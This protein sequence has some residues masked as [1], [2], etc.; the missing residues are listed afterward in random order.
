MEIGGLLVIGTERHESRRID[1]Q[2]RGRSGRQGE[3]GESQFFVSFEDEIVRLYST[4]KGEKFIDKVK[5]E[6]GK[7]TSQY[8]TSVI[9][10]AQ[11]NIEATFYGMRKNVL[12]Y[13]DIINEQRKETYKQRERALNGGVGISDVKA[14][15]QGMVERDYEELSVDE[16]ETKYAPFC[17]ENEEATLSVITKNMMTFFDVAV[18]YF[19]KSTLDEIARVAILNN[20]DKFWVEHITNLEEIKKEVWTQGYAQKEPTIY[21]K[22][23]AYELLEEITKEMQTETV[24]EVIT[25]IAELSI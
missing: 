14:F 22:K 9:E 8:A 6:H 16:F 24:M 2:L 10:D 15:A 12:Q 1:N 19:D 7:L 4:Y 25:R 20:I 13:D 11:T 17:G 21:F 3:P 18:E 5:D 23:I